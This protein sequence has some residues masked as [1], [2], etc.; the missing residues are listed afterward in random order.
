MKDLEQKHLEAIESTTRPYELSRPHWRKEAAK[1]CALITKN[2]GEIQR[3]EGMI[4]A[5]KHLAPAYESGL[6][7]AIAELEKQ[8][9]ELKG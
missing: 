8:L 3:L 5:Y 4:E 9:K 2:H 7:K 6:E 1:S